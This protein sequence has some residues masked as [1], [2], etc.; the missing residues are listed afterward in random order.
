MAASLVSSVT[1]DIQGTDSSPGRRGR[2]GAGPGP[3]HRKPGFR[4]GGPSRN[5]ERSPE[6][7]AGQSP[8]GA[9]SHS[10]PGSASL[11]SVS[12]AELDQA[13]L[14]FREG[15]LHGF[16]SSDLASETLIPSDGGTGRAG[17]ALKACGPF[18]PASQKVAYS[19]PWVLGWRAG[20]QPPQGAASAS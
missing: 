14:S 17:A 5:P 11:A 13:A 8:Q 16:I 12:A 9:G 4:A 2:L 6:S 18:G 19:T 15:T 7:P 10:V 3:P 20:F 1:R